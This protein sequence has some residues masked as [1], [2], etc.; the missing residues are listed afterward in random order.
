MRLERITPP[1]TR[2]D[3]LQLYVRPLMGQA[4]RHVTRTGVAFLLFLF[5]FSLIFG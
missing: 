3:G 5:L 2:K 4:L 1:R